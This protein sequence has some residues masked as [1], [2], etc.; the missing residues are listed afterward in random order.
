MIAAVRGE[1]NEQSVVT[2]RKQSDDDKEGLVFFFFFV[3]F[4]IGKMLG[5]HKMLAAGIGAL[6]AGSRIG[7]LVAPVAIGTMAGSDTF[8]VGQAVAIV[9][10]PCAIVVLAVR[11]AQARRRRVELTS[12]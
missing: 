10:I 9:T 1:F 6:I 11:S 12:A 7:A 2:S 3:L 8:S 4:V 5:R